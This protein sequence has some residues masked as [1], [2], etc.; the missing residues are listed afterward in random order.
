MKKK[1]QA[2]TNPDDL[3]KHLQ[4][5]SPFT[6]IVL[7]LSIALLVGFFAWSCLYTLKDKVIGKANVKDGE[8]SLVVNQSQLS[9]LAVGQKVYIL[10]QVG[11]IKDFVDDKPIVSAFT[12]ED[13]EYDYTVI[14]KEFKPIDLLIGK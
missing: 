1:D 7:V 13:G 9:K 6:W 14:V 10:E 11:E 5:T 2:F 4:Y 3:N 8:V 12:L